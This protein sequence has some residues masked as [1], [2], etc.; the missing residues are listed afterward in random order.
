MVVLWE[1]T[2]AIDNRRVITGSN[3]KIYTKVLKKYF[4]L[5]NGKMRLMDFIIQF[6]IILFLSEERKIEGEKRIF[7]YSL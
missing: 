6:C 5:E 2:A 4:S 7:L 1:K 3:I